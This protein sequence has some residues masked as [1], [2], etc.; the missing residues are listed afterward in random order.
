MITS[1]LYLSMLD[2]AEDP[3][4]LAEDALVVEKLNKGHSKRQA[5]FLLD[6]IVNGRWD[7]S[8]DSRNTVLNNRT[9]EAAGSESLWSSESTESRFTNPAEGQALDQV[10]DAKIIDSEHSTTNLL[11][12]LHPTGLRARVNTRSQTK[13]TI[14]HKADTFLVVIARNSGN[15]HDGSKD[16]FLRDAH[17]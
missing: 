6:G 8:P 16:L 5:L 10:V 2:K 17:I 15:G 1:R 14:V 9:L 13:A 12:D 4:N 7:G 11:P 3:L